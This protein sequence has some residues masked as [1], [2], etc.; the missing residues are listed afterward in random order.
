MSPKVWFIAFLDQILSSIPSFS[1]AVTHS[2]ITRTGCKEAS[3]L[4]RFLQA[5]A[6]RHRL[7]ILA[8]HLE[9]GEGLG[10]ET[11]DA[12]WLHDTCNVCVLA[13]FH[14]LG[15]VPINLSQVGPCLPPASIGCK[16]SEWWCT[17]DFLMARTCS[18]RHAR[19][20]CWPC[21]GS[22]FRCKSHALGR[23]WMSPRGACDFPRRAQ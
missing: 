5:T 15:H 2:C 13:F 9:M 11:G 8:R 6:L 12:T 22:A 19:R 16:Y 4:A 18:A 23:T 17:C 20:S 3:P 7:E 10:Q 14:L 21:L 1:R